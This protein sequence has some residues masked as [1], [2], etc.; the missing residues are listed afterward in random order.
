[1][2][3]IETLGKASVKI[4][5]NPTTGKFGVEINGLPDNIRFRLTVAD[6]KGNQVFDNEFSSNARVFK[7]TLDLS[8]QPKGIYLLKLSSGSEMSTTKIILQ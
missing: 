6:T 4:L 3:G 7:T 2:L 5:P 8:S 1:C